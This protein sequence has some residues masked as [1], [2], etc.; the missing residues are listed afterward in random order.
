M[1]YPEAVIYKFYNDKT[2]QMRFCWASSVASFKKV[3]S[4]RYLRKQIYEYFPTDTLTD[5]QK[6]CDEL[7]QSLQK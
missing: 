4:N 7:N 6:R 2:N 3:E 5:V 1:K